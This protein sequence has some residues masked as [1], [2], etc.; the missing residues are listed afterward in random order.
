MT[1]EHLRDLSRMERPGRMIFI[2]I[3]EFAFAPEEKRADGEALRTAPDQIGALMTVRRG[4]R[5]LVICHLDQLAQE[6]VCRLLNWA[7][8]RLFTSLLGRAV[9]VARTQPPLPAVPPMVE[10]G[11]EPDER[12]T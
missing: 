8:R 7:F 9:A 1:R 5:A 10:T 4:V 2:T 3:H 6:V 12:A 11:P